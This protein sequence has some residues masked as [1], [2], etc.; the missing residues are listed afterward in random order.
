[1]SLTIIEISVPGNVPSSVEIDGGFGPDIVEINQGPAGADAVITNASIGAVLTAAT[2]KTT[3]VDADTMPLTDSAASNALKKVTWANI[4]ATLA[5]YFGTVYAALVHTH[6]SADI[7]DATSAATANKL[8]LR[9]ATGGSNFAAVGASSVTSSGSIST[10]AINGFISTSGYDASIF[11]QG[12]AAS[13]Y[14]IGSEAEISTSGSDASISTS[15]ENAYIQ[16]SGIGGAIRTFGTDASIYTSGSNAYISTNGG[17]WIQTSSTFKFAS[18]AGTT[19]LSGTQT[20]DRAIAFPDASGTLALTTSNVATATAL[21]TARNIFGLSFDG[22]A[23]VSGDAVNTGHF[24]SIPTGGAAG[25]FVMLQG[26]APTLVAGRTAIYGATGGFGIKDGTGTARTVS[27]SGNLSLANNLT[28]SGNFALTLTT[29]ASTNVTLPTSGTLATLT[30]SETLTNKTL[31]SPTLTTPALG[32]PSS[33]T[34]T[35]A[36]GL[37]I[38]TGVSGLGTG[39]ATLLTGTPSG[40]GGPVGTTS[41]TLSGTLTVAQASNAIA[42]KFTAPNTAS[43]LINL[44]STSAT[45]YSS[46]GFYDE[47]NVAKGSFGYSNNG[48]GAIGDKVFFS[49]VS[50]PMVFSTNQGTTSHIS[51]ATSGGVSIGTT[52]D[53]GATN[54]LVAGTITASN[55]APATGVPA[56]LTGTPSGTGGPVGTTSP[57]ISNPTAS[58]AST[59]SAALLI[60]GPTSGVDTLRVQ[61]TNTAS[62]SSI[63]FIDSGGT[64]RGSFGYAGSTAGSFASTTFINA[65][66]TIPLTLGTASTERM[67]IHATSGGVS[68]GT[69]TDA[70]ATNLLVAGSTKSN[71]GFIYGTFTVG[72]FPATTYLEAVVTDALAPVIGATVAA[73]GSAKC[74]VMY[75][76][77]AKIVTAVL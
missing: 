18:G 50:V 55:Y 13:I 40:T 59:S 36:T 16:T 63:G 14:T 58:T 70:G 42:A 51:I 41:P 43:D 5:S 19:T 21:A 6:V 30:G 66:N 44:Q 64:Q 75:N 8:V 48:G 4:K 46:V 15:G 45:G 24:A 76:G 37:P 77:T 34:L 69:T 29:T 2:A 11:T 1:M 33:G 61:G 52:T 35:N 39:V 20:T 72:T 53:A 31:T 17:G 32:T 28:T 12:A 49:A 3:P 22:T 68:I 7:T 65:A 27:L 67:R 56:L 54:L 74:K 47:N 57:T 23:N 9:D 73:G 38:L 26:T 10:T 62:Y 25:H 60:S 71:G